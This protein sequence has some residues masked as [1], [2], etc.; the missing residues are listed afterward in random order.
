MQSKVLGLGL[1]TQQDPIPKLFGPSPMILHVSKSMYF[2][3]I[4]SE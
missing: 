2:K 4:P 1:E 3:G